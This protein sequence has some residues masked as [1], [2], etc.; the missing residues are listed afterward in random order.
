MTQACLEGGR[1]YRHVHTFQGKEADEVIFLLG[2]RAT[3][4]RAIRWVNANILNVAVTR[5]KK[6]VYIV[7]NQEIWLQYNNVF[8]RIP[9]FNVKGKSL[10]PEIFENTNLFAMYTFSLRRALSH[11]R[12]TR[13]EIHEE[14][15]GVLRITLHRINEEGKEEVLPYLATN[16]RE[17]ALSAGLA[18]LFSIRLGKA[19]WVVGPSNRED[20]QEEKHILSSFWEFRMAP[21]NSELSSDE[22][23]EEF[24]KLHPTMQQ[25]YELFLEEC[26][27]AEYAFREWIVSH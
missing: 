1:V 7:G 9:L 11:L 18:H 2:C 20:L 8:Q 19:S 13:V 27:Y 25:P 15:E 12:F 14:R 26:K 24:F 17:V 5:T 3:E 4:E 21:Q 23:H 6:R 10:G 22:A 16:Q